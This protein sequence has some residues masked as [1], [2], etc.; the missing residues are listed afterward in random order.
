MK[1]D[2]DAVY[3]MSAWESWKSS[4]LDPTERRIAEEIDKLNL[5][6][7]LRLNKGRR[8]DQPALLPEALLPA[9]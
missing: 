5:Y 6:E 3:N 9:G 4:S 8:A 7:L 1:T 2:V